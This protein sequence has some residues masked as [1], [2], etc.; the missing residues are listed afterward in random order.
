MQ[1]S[2]SPPK[3]AP[4]DPADSGAFARVCARVCN[5]SVLV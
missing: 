1:S 3:K 5:K 2:L 4:L